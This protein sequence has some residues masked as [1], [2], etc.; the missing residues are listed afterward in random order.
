MPNLGKSALVRDTQRWLLEL[1]ALREKALARHDLVQAEELQA[2]IA[3]V[4]ACFDGVLEAA[5]GA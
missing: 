1:R 2:E 5:A 3:D 4:L